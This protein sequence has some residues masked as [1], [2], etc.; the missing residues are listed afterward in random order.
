MAEIL[1]VDD[2]NKILDVVESYL[3][4]KGFQVKVA[5]NG[6][7]ALNIINTREIDL[8]VL[9]LMLPDISGEEVCQSIRD[10]KNERVR[11]TPIIM[12][13]AKSHEMAIIEGLRT[14]AD[15]YMVKPFSL[16][17]LQVRIETVLRRFDLSRLLLKPTVW[18][19][20]YLMVDLTNKTVRINHE[21]INLT[22]S[23][24]RI[25]MTMLAQPNRV[26]T[27]EQLIDAVFGDDFDSYDRVIDTHIKNLRQKIEK[28]PKE[29][30]YIKTIYGLGYRFG[31]EK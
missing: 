30:F 18:Q 29:P 2:E 5:S 11:L 17:E 10:S 27:R 16:K 31:G 3:V 14:G 12:L 7:D 23:E 6:S 13:S 19:D 28:N 1:I 9:D 24:L 22:V 20:D 4:S 25:L 21:L 15:D 26:F 8:V